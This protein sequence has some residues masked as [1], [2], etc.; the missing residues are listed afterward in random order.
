MI[1]DERDTIVAVGSAPGSAERGVVRVSGPGALAC[2]ARCCIDGGRLAS[3]STPSRVPGVGIPL[4][5]FASPLIGDAWVWPGKRSYTGQPTVELHLPG[6]PPLLAAVVDRLIAG[7][8]RLAAPGEF[9]LRAFLSG[10]IDL[11]QAEAV[12]GVIDARDERT[13]QTALDRF[14]GG[15]S[16]PLATLRQDLLGLLAEVE[17]GLDFVD[18]EGVTF[19]TQRE[20]DGRLEAAAAA[21]RSTRKLAAGRGVTGELPRVV[22]AGPTNAGKSSLFNALAARYSATGDWSPAL[23]SDQAGTTR[24]WVSATL[25]VRGIE[26]EL[27]DTAGQNLALGGCIDRSAQRLANVEAEVAD[28]VVWCDDRPLN[29]KEATGPTI[30]VQTKCDQGATQHGNSGTS[31]RPFA[32]STL[33]GIGLAALAEEFARQIETVLRDQAAPQTRVIDA[34]SVGE[35]ALESAM[36]LTSSGSE[37]LLAAELRSALTA[38]GRVTGE[39]TNDD[40]LDVIFSRFCIGK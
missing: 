7:G 36:G 21:I 24:D 1:P 31:E 4:V 15:V 16:T 9:T 22:L 5:G 27:I 33:T 40:V 35:A 37:D 13:L 39:V 10:R 29:G 20:I 30:Q 17:A 3:L 14:A 23:V 12:L 34:L 19:I 32:T 25:N 38:I 6:L 11:V 2:V 26:F 18:E 8:A 28:L